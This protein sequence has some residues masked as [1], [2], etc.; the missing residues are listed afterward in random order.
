MKK[1]ERGK[2]VPD[3]MLDQ[4]LFEM[5]DKE[6]PGSDLNLRLFELEQ[7]DAGTLRVCRI[8]PSGMGLMG[9]GFPPLCA[10]SERIL[11]DAIIDLAAVKGEAPIEDF[12]TP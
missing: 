5:R 7:E 2:E 1:K 8:E 11:K 6:A 9:E 12:R 10:T 4:R 3:W